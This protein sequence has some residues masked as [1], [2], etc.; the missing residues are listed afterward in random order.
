MGWKTMETAPKDGTYVLL[1]RHPV[2]WLGSYRVGMYGD[3]QYSTHPE[4]EWRDTSG[5]WMTP[6]Y[7]MAIPTP[8]DR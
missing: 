5:R 1:C 3:P 6:E 7:W 8:P 4:P 2:V